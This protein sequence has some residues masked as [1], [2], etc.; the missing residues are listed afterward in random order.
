MIRLVG[1]MCLSVCMSLSAATKVATPTQ[2]SGTEKLTHTHQQKFKSW[3]DDTLALV[4]N[5]LGTLPQ[6]H[7]PVTLKTKSFTTEPVP[8]GQVERGVNQQIDGLYLVANRHAKLSQLTYD[9][10]L[11]HEISHLYLPYLDYPS[12]WLSEGFATYMQNVIMLENQVFDRAEFIARMKSGLKRGKEN[13]FSAQGKLSSVTYMMREKRAFKRVY[14]SGTAFFIE[15][16]IRL[17]THGTSLIEVV[18]KFAHCCK[19]EVDSGSELVKALDKL[20]G[21]RV[22]VPLYYQYKDRLDFPTIESTLIYQLA[23]Y[24]RPNDLLGLKTNQ[25]EMDIFSQQLLSQP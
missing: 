12:F 7:L 24:Y 14:W 10:T 3:V 25:T 19:G 6:S 11:Y 17:Q 20:V 23:N 21:H 22:F 15:A 8:W 9:W 5:T 16:D 18:G 4:E 1:L 2:L 13:T